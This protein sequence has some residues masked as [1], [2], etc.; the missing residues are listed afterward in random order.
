MISEELKSKIH[1]LS[2]EKPLIC[3]DYDGTIVPIGYTQELAKVSFSIKNKLE[4]LKDFTT[5]AIVT[6]RSVSDI[7]SLSN[8]DPHY[9]IGNHGLE[10]TYEKD[11]INLKRCL[12]IMNL[13]EKQIN[14]L[15]KQEQIFKKFPVEH[16]KYSFTSHYQTIEDQTLLSKAF[17]SLT[18]TPRLI[19]GK[20]V[21]NVVPD[22]GV[23]KGTS[24][25]EM[26]EKLSF[27]HAFFAGDDVTDEDVFNLGNP[28]ILTV[29]IGNKLNTNADFSLQKQVHIE[30][31]IDCFLNAFS[32]Y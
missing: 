19:D 31:V 18:P 3:F 22:I 8:I 30:G 17:M 23:N 26:M 21:L 15:Q 2:K 20:N 32:S 10:N 14:S 7:L 25:V 16:K 29:Y 13:W 24:I 1:F 9:Y 5:V 27:T 28:N 12:D 6:G 4:K 11:N